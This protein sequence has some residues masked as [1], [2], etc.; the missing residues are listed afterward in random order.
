MWWFLMQGWWSSSYYIDVCKQR[1]PCGF[2]AIQMQITHDRNA[3]KRILKC[4][5]RFSD[6]MTVQHTKPWVGLAWV[7]MLAETAIDVTLNTVSAPHVVNSNHD[8]RR[9]KPQILKDKASEWNNL[10]F[11][12]D[13]QHKL[14]L[15][16]MITKWSKWR[17]CSPWCLSGS[18]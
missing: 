12:A 2:S 6:Q 9:P 11:H 10:N 16:L 5:N 13:F 17:N 18:S 1:C 8:T 15:R 4:A 14:R 7:T 3:T